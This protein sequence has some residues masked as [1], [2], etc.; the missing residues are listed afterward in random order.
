LYYISWHAYYTRSA[1][2]VG[3]LLSASPSSSL[4]STP[5]LKVKK[6]NLYPMLIQSV[7]QI[8]TS[9][10]GSNVFLVVRFKAQFVIVRQLPLKMMIASKVVE[11]RKHNILYI[12]LD[13]R[14]ITVIHVTFFLTASPCPPIWHFYFKNIFF[15]AHQAM[16]GKIKY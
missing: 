2:W 5:G 6:N 4:P 8:W 14:S 3:Q 9:E 13:S 7:W 11:G 12:L 1:T 15:K 10:A 16:N